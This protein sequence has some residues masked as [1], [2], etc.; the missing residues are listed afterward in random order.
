ML[1]ITIL[2]SLL[3]NV[4]RIFYKHLTIFTC[5]YNINTLLEFHSRSHSYFFIYNKF[6]YVILIENNQF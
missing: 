6:S 3:S 5:N 2:K 1:K 4:K